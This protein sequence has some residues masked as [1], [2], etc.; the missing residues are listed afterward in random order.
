MIINNPHVM[1]TYVGGSR[2]LELFDETSDYDIIVLVDEHQPNLD[3]NN[4]CRWVY[5][6]VHVHLY[7]DTLSEFITRYDCDWG[8]SVG[9][10]NLYKFSHNNILYVNPQY[11]SLVKCLIR[12]NYRMGMLGAA[13]VFHTQHKLVSE[14]LSNN[15]I[16][17]T[18]RLYHLCV[19]YYILCN[20]KMDIDF[21]LKIKAYSKVDISNIEKN[22]IQNMVKQLTQIITYIDCKSIMDELLNELQHESI[23][24]R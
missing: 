22:K 24:C 15:K 17:P 7:Q 4:I 6:D 18:K 9:L 12:N 19:A 14:V 11:S 20:T 23:I 13:G 16:K 3:W 5:K 10:M 21:I 8:C 1:L 2:S